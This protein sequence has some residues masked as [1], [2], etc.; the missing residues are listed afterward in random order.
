MET[1]PNEVEQEQSREQIEALLKE[2]FEKKLVVDLVIG[3]RIANQPNMMVDEI[4]EEVVS[5][6]SLE[7]EEGR[8]YFVPLQINRVKKVT[9]RGSLPP[10]KKQ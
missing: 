2:A 7:D 4:D 6:S 9:L 1:P 5:L 8:G 10:S 3:D